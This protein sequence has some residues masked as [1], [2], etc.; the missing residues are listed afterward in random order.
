MD[1]PITFGT[2]GWR[3]TLDEFT[4]ERVAL[5]G[6]AVAAYLRDHGLSDRPVAV[7]YD[8]RESSPQFAD[9]VSR[10]L[11]DNG[12]E[13]QQ[14]TTAVPTPLIAWT[15]ADRRL[16][17]GLMITASH[18]PPEYNGIKFITAAGAPALPPVTDALETR[19][20]DPIR[21]AAAIDGQPIPLASRDEYIAHLFDLVDPGKL[22]D[23]SIAYD[24]MHGSGS[25]VTAQ[26]LEQTGAAVDAR[27]TAA[28]PTFGG[29]PPEPSADY[30]STL[31]ETVQDSSIDIGLAN[32]GDADRIAVISPE[33]GYVDEN[34]LFATLYAYLL[35][36]D[37]GPAVRTVSTTHLID[38]I[39]EDHGTTTIE[40]PV[41]FKWVAAA[42]RDHDAVIG[43][44]E[45]GGFSIRGHVREKDGV[46]LALLI[47]AMSSEEPIDSRIDRLLET[48]G[49]IA[50]EK[51]SM[52]CP[53]SEKSRVMDAIGDA[54]PASIA[55]SEI[56]D[57][58]TV[59]G[60]K[61][62]LA[63]DSW[64]LVRPS[65]TEPAIRMYAEAHSEDRV[66]S[67]LAAVGDVV[68]PLV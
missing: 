22:S 15:V 27:R 10:V 52:D 11:Q 18:N 31:I 54:L 59:D 62:T 23:L 61:I 1:T 64:V 63:D 17:G 65:G 56:D 6:Q 29:N 67:I 34:L 19:L 37:T 43:G 46:L 9:T 58:S 53:N 57:I 44:E 24:A 5:V 49:H 40:T 12:I 45:S 47:A 14:A 36:T 21:L 26:V 3:A 13:V 30:L 33:R 20:S 16:A 60:Y 68:E 35:E 2:D 51:Q 4:D 28:D 39:A 8:A 50:Q 48:Y 7:G 66:E 25:E 55:G 32:D 38:R 42:M 41:G